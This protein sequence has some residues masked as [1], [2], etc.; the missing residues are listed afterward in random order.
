MDTK[1][2]K[3]LYF[4]FLALGFYYSF[5][6]QNYLEAAGAMGVGLAFDPFNPKQTWKERPLW[7]KAVLVL[8]LAIVATL[9]GLGIGINDK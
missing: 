6:S 4:S 5:Y 2:N 3:I 9:F 7:Q 1:F 8:N